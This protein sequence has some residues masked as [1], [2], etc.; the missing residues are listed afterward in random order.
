VINLE[1]SGIYIVCLTNKIKISN[2][3]GDKRRE[4][5]GTP[6]GLGNF[7]V[8]KAKVLKTRRKDYFKTFGEHHVE[9]IP[10]FNTADIDNIEQK[11]KAALKNYRIK[12]INGRRLEWMENITKEELISIVQS[13]NANTLSKKKTIY[14]LLDLELDVIEQHLKLKSHFYRKIKDALEILRLESP[15]I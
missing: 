3:A 5:R 8:G 11:I 15:L 2:Y 13:F 9:F 4:H 1:D 7:K 14:E 6:V 10:Q 12:G